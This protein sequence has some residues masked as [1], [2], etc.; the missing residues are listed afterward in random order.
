MIDGFPIRP[1]NYKN[2][3]DKIFAAVGVDNQ[4]ACLF[5]HQLLGEVKQV[6]SLP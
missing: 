4:E 3:V 6:I 5:L 2:K 1:A